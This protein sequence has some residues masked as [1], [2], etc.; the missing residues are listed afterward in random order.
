MA[1]D[2]AERLKIAQADYSRIAGL[3][4]A[5][6]VTASDADR[7]HKAAAQEAS[8]L[9]VEV[10]DLR[11]RLATSD[12]QLQRA[13]SRLTEET[14]AA[15]DM[16]RGDMTTEWAPA[17]E[18]LGGEG[19]AAEPP[20]R[21]PLGGIRFDANAANAPRPSLWALMKGGAGDGVGG[22]ASFVGAR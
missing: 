3:Y 18:V 11:S 6:G 10:D 4:T 22:T 19:E 5:M 7:R 12:L 13:L 2:L 20:P 16:G 1:E 21:A 14:E 15:W 9:H 17:S 8:R